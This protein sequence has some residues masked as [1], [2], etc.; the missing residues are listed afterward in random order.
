MPRGQTAPD[1]TWIQVRVPKRV[2]EELE[3][4]VGVEA[5]SISW[6]ARTLIIEALSKREAAQ[7]DRAKA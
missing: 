4:M 3:E 2:K 5:P 7:Q 6:V 1:E